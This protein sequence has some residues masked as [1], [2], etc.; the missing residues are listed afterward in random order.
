[1]ESSYGLVGE[2]VITYEIK[3]M[4][5]CNNMDLVAIVTKENLLEVYRIF[6][7]QKIFQIEEQV[8]ITFTLFSPD[9]KLLIYMNQD[10]SHKIVKTENGEVLFHVKKSTTTIPSEPI[11]PVISANWV[12]YNK[13]K[14]IN[15]LNPFKQYATLDQL[16]FP[17]GPHIFSDKHNLAKLNYFSEIS[18]EFTMVIMNDDKANSMLSINGIFPVAKYNVIDLIFNDEK[19]KLMT[20][21][22]IY[23][24][25]K[26]DVSESYILLSLKSPELPN[27]KLFIVNVETNIL[28]FYKDEINM[29]GYLLS[30]VE[31]HMNYIKNTFHSILGQLKEIQKNFY[32]KI[33]ILED[34]IKSNN[35][36]S[37]N[38]IAE[39]ANY[40]KTGALSSSLSQ[41]FSKELYDCKILQ[42]MDET[43]NNTF[44]NIQDFVMES[45]LNAIERVLVLLNYLENCAKEETYLLLG[46][47]LEDLKKFSD[48]LVKLHLKS[49][50]FLN[51]V[52]EA[53]INV[54]NLI[55]WMN[56][57]VLKNMENETE[58]ENSKSYLNKFSFD[59]DRL[60]HLLEDDNLF[61]MKHLF[62]YFQDNQLKTVPKKDEKLINLTNNIQS[63]DNR[64]HLEDE[65]ED[66]IQAYIMESV[67]QQ[68][69]QSSFGLPEDN[70]KSQQLSLYNDPINVLFTRSE[71]FNFKFLLQS[72]EEMWKKVYSKPC[73]TISKTFQSRKLIELGDI[74]YQNH[75]IAYSV[76]DSSTEQFDV[77]YLTK[78]GDI[79][80][81]LLVRNNTAKK[82]AQD[83]ELEVAIIQIPDNYTLKEMLI[84]RNNYILCLL[85]NNV[86]NMQSKEKP[87]SIIGQTSTKAMHV[88]KLKERASNINILE[89]LMARSNETRANALDFQRYYKID[90][91]NVAKL[92]ASQ[93]GMVSV[94]VDDNKM[95][96]LVDTC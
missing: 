14:S 77:A 43:I 75:V 32:S 69:L 1:M 86:I 46:L 29:L 63:N 80:C 79:D 20:S 50:Q 87:H 45:I 5:W 38:P 51:D 60:Y 88:L 49:D 26:N 83:L 7:I 33:A 70:S 9:G 39:L 28:A 8:D 57:C 21:D 41:Y 37:S 78:L 89:R 95:V 16:I 73:N 82:A 35:N 10:G 2:K 56:K 96:F 84:L 15:Y 92:R 52:T 36:T 44:N 91:A 3:N 47:E 30:Y 25:I 68:I 12:V 24:Y 62:E 72:I 66:S 13:I 34:C 42:K 94:V 53:K 40:L 76:Q 64:V 58:I 90:S 61:Y 23:N 19:M 18:E 81:I 11:M 54:R 17:L 31:E 67:E 55:V 4:V 71:N 74:D 6:K 59:L 93:K 65:L 85:V 48:Y 27:S 22:I